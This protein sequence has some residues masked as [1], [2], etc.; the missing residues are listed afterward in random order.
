M[1]PVREKV[2]KTEE[3]QS[4]TPQ[5]RPIV[6]THAQVLSAMES[7]DTRSVLQERHWNVEVIERYGHAGK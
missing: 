5:L 4:V 2:N 1:E 7:K 6:P 3:I